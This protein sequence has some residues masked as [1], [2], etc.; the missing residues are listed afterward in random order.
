MPLRRAARVLE[1]S[2]EALVPEIRVGKTE[3]DI[4]TR[5]QWLMF[6]HGSDGIPDAPIVASGP[7][8]ALPHTTYTTAHSRTA[9]C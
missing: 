5:W 1:S 2:I 6:E 4:A 8:S 7:N 3:K 9:T